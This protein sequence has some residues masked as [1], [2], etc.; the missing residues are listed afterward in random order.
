[1]SNNSQLLVISDTLIHQDADGRYCINDFHKAAGNEQ[2]HQPSNWLRL[3]QTKALIEEI[4]RSSEMMNDSSEVRSDFSEMRAA[5]EIRNG[6]NNR[7][8]YVVK[9]LV[10][11]YAMWISPAFNLK[12]IRAYDAMAT[13]A[14]H[15]DLAYQTLRDKFIKVNEAYIGL[16][17]EKVALLE[18]TQPRFKP[19]AATLDEVEAIVRCVAEGYSYRDIGNLLGRTKR[20]VAHI[21]AKE[22]EG[23]YAKGASHE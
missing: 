16:L 15:P 22:K 5:I 4:N 14:N 12:V 18:A 10:Y 1:M 9:E 11:S 13:G 23:Y 17:Q 19:H 8:T 6:G 7:G 2:R 21:V 3:D 20:S